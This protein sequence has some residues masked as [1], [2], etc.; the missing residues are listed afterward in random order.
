MARKNK[1]L[2]D[3]CG[4]LAK[5]TIKTM[6]PEDLREIARMIPDSIINKK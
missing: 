4:D 6:K 1:T 3:F 5:E 2:W